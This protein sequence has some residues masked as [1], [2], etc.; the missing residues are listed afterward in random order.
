MGSVA[1]SA[2]HFCHRLLVTESK[3]IASITFTKC[4]HAGSVNENDE[5]S[6]HHFS[7]SLSVYTVFLIKNVKKKG[8]V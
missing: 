8:G 5:K 4:L 1:R 7:F 3:I 6:V 2:L